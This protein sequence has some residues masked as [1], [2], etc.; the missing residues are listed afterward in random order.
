MAGRRGRETVLKTI[1]FLI[2]LGIIVYLGIVAFVVI[3]EK[4]VNTEAPWAE[5]YDAIVVL[6]AQVKPDRDPS[7]QLQWR[8]D[9]A[10]KAWENKP[11]PIVVCG[12][13]G[14]DE[15]APEA[16]VMKEYL[17]AHGVSET[18]VYTDDSSFN[19]NQNLTNAGKIL[20]E[21]KTEKIL[22]VTSDYHVPR[23][24]A[25]ASDM[26]LE[27]VGMGSPCKPEFWIKNHFRE[28]LAWCK[29]WAVKYLKIPLE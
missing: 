19:T 20:K 22:I 23:A 21:L 24:L 9:A 18:D 17:I 28:A 1:F 26:E 12:A 4:T 13:Q 5:Q 15:P 6:G 25:L 27:A 10:L 16:T 14:K 3:R 29:Y 11:V 8:L 2:L 7:V